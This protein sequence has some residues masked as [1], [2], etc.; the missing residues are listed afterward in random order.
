MKRTILLL[1]II[2][3]LNPLTSSAYWPVTTEDNLEIAATPD[4]HDRNPRAIPFT[5]GSILV[6]Y[7]LE[8]SGFMYQIVDFF[9]DLT[10]EEPQPVF[11][12]IVNTSAAG[13][14]LIIDGEGGAYLMK[15]YADGIHAQCI[16]ST[17][18]R[19]WGET[20]VLIY[21]EYESSYE[22]CMND[23]G[24]FFIAFAKDEEAD[25]DDVQMQKV[26]A[27]GSLPWGEWGLPIS[28]SSYVTERSPKIASDDRGG[29]FVIWQDGSTPSIDPDLMGQRF[30][31]NGQ[32]LWD[33]NLFVALEPYI[34]PIIKDGQGGIIVKSND[35]GST[36][37]KHRRIDAD[38]NILWVRDY[39]TRYGDYA[40]GFLMGE[41]GFYYC[42]FNYNWQYWGQRVDIQ[43]N[44]YWPTYPEQTGAPFTDYIQPDYFTTKKAFTFNYPYFFGFFILDF[45][46]LNH[47]VTVNYL[48]MVG[49]RMLGNDGI[50]LMDSLRYEPEMSQAIPL[51]DESVAF[52]C[53]HGSSSTAGVPYDVLGKR[54][55]LDGSLGGPLHLL[56]DLEPESSS[57]QIPPT[58]GNFSYNV[59]IEDTYVVYSDFDAWVEVT[60]PDGDTREITLR[61]GIHIDSNSV[62]ERFDLVQ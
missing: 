33:E 6:A 19:L 24:G 53:M 36:V 41:P 49:E 8:G 16:D 22:L 23:E 15:H 42:G 7:G 40:D 1:T 61:E 57:I 14:Q 51:P 50:Y 21:P 55:N 46:Y 54:V 32:P 11:P 60:M 20:G 2:C 38:G 35:D 31:G 39:L 13:G 29:L 47:Q 9:G 27:D 25:W 28:D 56:V 44:N 45:A 10:Y 59:A 48:S 5:N 3:L 30:D 34:H 17:G 37:D 18:T 58:G 4:L 43:G 12:G 62:I 26:N 52:V